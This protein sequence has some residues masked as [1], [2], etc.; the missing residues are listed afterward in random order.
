MTVL[1]G[2]RVRPVPC[3][4]GLAAATVAGLETLGLAFHQIHDDP[5]RMAQAAET[6]HR[7]LG[8]ESVAV[9][10]DLAVEA[11]ALGAEVDLHA[12]VR[13]PIYPSIQ[14]PLAAS[15][16]S[17]DITPPARIAEQ[18]R[19]PVVTEAI[20]LLKERVGSTA[21]VG[22]WLPG[23]YTLALQVVDMIEMVTGVAKD[24]EAVGRVLDVLTGVVIE[25]G[26]AY[27]E[28]GAD[29]ITVHEMGG[30]PGFIGPRP[31]E[32]VVQPRLKRLLEALPAPRVLSVCGNTNRAMPLL[33][34]CGAD[35]L[36]VDQTNDLARSRETLGP[37]VVLF[38][39]IDPVG[40]LANGDE[41]AVRAAVRQAIEAGVDAVWPGCDLAPAAPAANL[42]AMVDEAL[43]E[44]PGF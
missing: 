15:P 32:K 16:A 35:A 30:S 4:S 11:G 1:S 6:A 28:A 34:A 41:A 17:F 3:F 21:A 26:H 5:E 10:F 2:Q 7:V 20:R 43:K 22:A 36:S 18:G 19:I 39:N 27:H 38:G 40:T 31:F 23:P 13:H 14:K 29:F 37:D 12:D 9:P 42:R 25:V 8:F 33:A 44:Q 24:P